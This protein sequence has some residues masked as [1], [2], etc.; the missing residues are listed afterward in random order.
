M[1]ISKIQNTG[2]TSLMVKRRLQVSAPVGNKRT[3]NENKVARNENKVVR[4]EK[5]GQTCG[6]MYATYL[7]VS[8]AIGAIYLIYYYTE[9]GDLDLYLLLFLL[10]QLLHH[11]FYSILVKQWF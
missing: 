4:D 1:G 10:K 9:H 8:A 3:V 7:V 6:G 5:P 11:F 2:A